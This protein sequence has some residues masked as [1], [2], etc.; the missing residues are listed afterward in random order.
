MKKTEVENQAVETQVLAEGAVVVAAPS[1]VAVVK[2]NYI[3]AML[4]ATKAK[5]MEVN[6]GLDLDFVRLGQW[7]KLNKKGQFVLSADEEESFGDTLDVVVAKGETRYML[8][9]AKKSPEDG[10]LIVAEKTLA[11]A[12]TLLTEW[13]ANNPDPTA[14]SRYELSD[15]KI[16][17]LAYVVMV[18]TITAE[19]MPEVYLMSFPQTGS[20]SF[21]QYAMSVF[22]GDK[23]RGIPR[24]SGVN[25]VVT[26]ISNKEEKGRNESYL[27]YTFEVVGKFVPA[28]YGINA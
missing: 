24:N 28:D 10:E 19:D 4:E 9:G 20:Y 2:K 18:S 8:W 12:E 26:R 25:T 5:F 13:L 17:Y 1:A 16:S 21:G 27:A 11:E 7:L 22:K 6:E 15:I 23:T 14:A 3:T